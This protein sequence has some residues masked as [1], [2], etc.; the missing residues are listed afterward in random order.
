MFHQRVLDWNHFVAL[1]THCCVLLWFVFSAIKTNIN[2]WTLLLCMFNLIYSVVFMIIIL[3]FVF[4]SSWANVNEICCQ[5]QNNESKS[6]RTSFTSV[7]INN[8][9]AAAAGTDNSHIIFHHALWF[10]VAKFNSVLSAPAPWFRCR[11]I[12]IWYWQTCIRG[13]PILN[14]M[15]FQPTPWTNHCVNIP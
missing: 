9:A 8:I 4:A 13:Q 11:P 15:I 12:V 3:F 7:R 5:W 2:K 10:T 6:W 14:L 1:W